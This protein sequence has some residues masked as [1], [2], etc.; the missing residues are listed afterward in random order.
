MSTRTPSL[1]AS[2]RA[3]TDRYSVSSSICGTS[4][5]KSEYEASAAYLA[6]DLA[7]GQHSNINVL[8][9]EES[10]LCDMELNDD[11]EGWQTKGGKKRKKTDSNSSKSTDTVTH[12]PKVTEGLTVIFVSTVENQLIAALS[13]LKLSSALE[14]MCPECILEVRPNKRLNLIAVDTRNGQTTRTL[15]ACSELC[16]MKVRAYEP[17]PR[18]YAVGVITDVDP[19]LSEVEIEQ[20]VRSP[21]GRVARLRR[22]GKSTAVKLSFS[23][24]TLPSYVYLGHVRHPVSLFKERPI[25]CRKCCAYGHREATCKRPP[26]C[27]RCGDLHES[28]TECSAQEKCANCGQPH[29]A[30]S[31]SCPKWKKESETRN[32]ARQHAVDFRAARTAVQQSKTANATQNGQ[33]PP[34]PPKRRNDPIKERNVSAM[35]YAAALHQKGKTTKGESQLNN[36][37]TCTVESK[38]DIVRP[39]LNVTPALKPQP[40]PSPSAEPTAKSAWESWI[41]LL[42]KATRMACAFLSTVDA[43]WARLLLSFLNMIIPLMES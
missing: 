23:T 2:Q 36:H 20:N 17:V 42:Q 18:H 34:S 25:Q 11:E 8:N 16:G 41:P 26:I 43:Q 30:T 5:A 38:A 32:Y 13:S 9:A 35:D 40:P 28:N 15:L 1:T 6:E 33:P 22:L 4:L 12:W 14:Q 29:A 31:S 7:A 3:A 21:E 39:A 27:S 19:A 37:H 24:T 10:Q